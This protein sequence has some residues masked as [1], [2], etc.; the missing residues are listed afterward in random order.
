MGALEEVTKLKNDLLVAHKT[1]DLERVMDVLKA[2]A[3]FEKIDEA[4]V[5]KTKA[6]KTLKD[7]KSAYDK[8]DNKE[9]SDIIF[10]ILKK[11]TKMAKQ[12]AAAKSV[13]AKEAAANEGAP[14]ASTKTASS[15]ASLAPPSQVMHVEKGPHRE[16][17]ILVL[18]EALQGGAECKMKRPKALATLLKM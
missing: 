11:W 4:L 14:L 13:K 2:L 16:K 6:G 17:I 8:L 7:L 3:A 15:E 12:E 9:V 1:A 18:S 5:K 10:D